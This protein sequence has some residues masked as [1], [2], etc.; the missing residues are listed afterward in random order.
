GADLLRKRIGMDRLVVSEASSG[1]QRRYPGRL[2]G[3]PPTPAPP[4]PAEGDEKTIE[5]YIREAKVWKERLAQIREWLE[6]VSG[7]EDAEQTPEQQRET[8]RERLEREVREKGYRNVRA[9]HL[10]EGA[11]TLLIRTLIAEGVRSS[12]LEGETL[13]IRGA[14]VSTHPKLVE[15]AAKL[16]VRSRSGNIEADIVLEGAPPAEGA[17]D[18]TSL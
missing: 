1:E 12:Q 10:I 8:L 3:P 18:A 17:K 7:G 5:D 14:N 16:E 6:Q 11:P 4:P 9:E 15:G 2:V 13:D